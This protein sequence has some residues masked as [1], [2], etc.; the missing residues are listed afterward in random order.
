MGQ[1]ASR[2][3]ANHSVYPDVTS[4][5]H[6]ETNN[7]DTLMSEDETMVGV[8]SA[9]SMLSRSSLLQQ[10]EVNVSRIQPERTR[11]TRGSP[12]ST[13]WCRLRNRIYRTTRSVRPGHT[14][15]P[16]NSTAV[17]PRTNSSSPQSRRNVLVDSLLSNTSIRRRSRISGPPRPRP[18][19]LHS[20]DPFIRNIDPKIRTRQR[21]SSDFIKRNF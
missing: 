3:S 19:S 2:E 13:L 5:G 9:T 10:T 17:V 6:R 20:L 12:G 8:S 11:R 4:S 1:H 15:H 21:S 16:T 7:A 18:Q 14:S